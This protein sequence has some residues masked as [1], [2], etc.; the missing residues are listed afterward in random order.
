MRNTSR[1]GKIR[2]RTLTRDAMASVCSARC[3]GSAGMRC[4]E[5]AAPAPRC[6]RSYN[7]ALCLSQQKVSANKTEAVA[8]Q[9]IPWHTGGLG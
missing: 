3:F 5:N 4:A 7:P 8:A 1:A 6:R 9:K 2:A